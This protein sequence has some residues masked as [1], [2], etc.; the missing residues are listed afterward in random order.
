MAYNVASLIMMVI[1]SLSSVYVPLV[2][3]LLSADNRKKALKTAGIFIGVCLFF[4]LCMFGV[5]PFFFHF[6][7]DHKFLSGQVYAYYLVICM[8]FWAIAQ[9]LYPFLMFHKKNYVIM[10]FAI[11]GAVISI[12]LNVVLTPKLHTWGAIIA[13]GSSYFTIA[14]LYVVYIIFRMK[15]NAIGSLLMP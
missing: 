8:F 11:A 3:R 10:F 4:C 1:L 12:G 14:M 9:A 13:N 5:I 15:K 7:I 2:Y 6:I